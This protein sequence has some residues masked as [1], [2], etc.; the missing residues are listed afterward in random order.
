MRVYRRFRYAIRSMRGPTKFI[1]ILLIAVTTV[2]LLQ[3]LE[4]YHEIQTL[5]AMTLKVVLQA[6][7]GG[8]SEQ[9]LEEMRTQEGV[10]AVSEVWQR[11][12][13]VKTDKK[14]VTTELIGLDAEYVLAQMQ[15]TGM[16]WD[17]ISGNIYPA[18]SAMPYGV[19]NLSLR[20]AVFNEQVEP[21]DQTVVLTDGMR[22]RVVGV[23]EDQTDTPTIYMNQKNENAIGEDKDATAWVT[24]KGRDA[25]EK[26]TKKAA[27]L[28][29]FAWIEET[30]EVEL[31]PYRHPLMRKS[32]VSSFALI[33]ATI[34]V[35]AMQ[36]ITRVKVDRKMD[37]TLQ[38]LGLHVKK[39]FV[40]S[41]FRV[42]YLSVF[43]FAIG[44]LIVSF[45]L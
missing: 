2:F 13:T 6:G 34:A 14:E 33:F 11:S 19:I 45:N 36:E 32:I 15:E 38:R 44:F 27:N 41:I 31:N 1:P 43:G 28:G 18:E 25:A 12:G 5:E 21:L 30:A 9:V 39:S 20:K 23:A 24:V 7:E 40:F 17:L 37:N 4:I 35:I 16:G 10:S 26:L 8:L 22:I 29:L 3:S 42:V